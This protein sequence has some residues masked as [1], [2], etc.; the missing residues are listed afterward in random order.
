MHQLSKQLYIVLLSIHGLIRGR[1]LE[2]GRDADTGGQTLYVVELAHALARHPDVGKVD[3][4]TRRVVDARV[5]KDYAEPIERLSDNA[6]I[7]RI[8]AGPEDYIAKEQLW[9]H[10]DSFAD[11]LASFIRDSKTRPD[12][13][14][15]H[16]ADAG[17]VGSHLAN[18][19]EIPLIHTGHSLGRVKRSRLLAV[20]LT[21]QEMEERFRMS[22]RIEAEEST[23]ATAERVITSTHQEI[24]EQYEL[25]DHYQPEQ[26][27]V[28]PPGTDLKQ[29]TPPRGGELE[30][31]LFADLVRHLQDPGKPLILALSR[32]DRRK[33]ISALVEAYG[34]S[35]T[36][37]KLAN[38]LI[39]AGNRDDID[40]LEDGAQEVFHDL[41][42]TIDRHELYG[43]VALPKHHQRH[44]VPMIY[45]IAA[46]TGGVF[47]NPA[48][49][50]PFGLTLI[51]AAASGLPIVATEDGGPRD[52]IG[53]CQ[54]G[55]LIDPLEPDSIAGA[56]LQLLENPDHW[57]RCVKHGLQGVREHYSWEAHV[58]RYLE[59]I[60]PIARHAEK[61]V[62]KPAQ[63]RAELYRD[64]VIVSDLDQNLIGDDQSLSQLIDVLHR[65]RKSTQFVIATGRRIDSALK[66]MKKHGIP[67]PDVL[68]T[69]SGTEIYHAPKLTA[70]IAWAKHIDYHW[71]PHQV[72]TILS[73]YP[74]LENQP[75]LEQSRFKISYYFDPKL[76][77]IE[78]IKQ[79][80]H[81]EEQSV[82]V[83]TA[84]GQYLDILPLRASKG[85][86]LRYIADRKNIPLEAV[87]V[88]GGSGADE[89]MMRGNTLAAVVA[90]RHHE[91]LS[92][93]IDVERIYFSSEPNAAGILE[94]LAYYDFFASCKDPRENS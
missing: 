58:E 81:R 93:L 69:S 71:S 8:D 14:H 40:D 49:T 72:R 78:E 66:L 59:L 84:F 83:Q 10:L 37:Q 12:I 67:E 70:D 17:Y 48:L 62:R 65:H 22:R 52:I 3:L 50:E 18:L 26:M 27:C 20:G 28:I 13:L 79:M 87:F 1:E 77:D 54:N 73:G 85:M 2:L 80:L 63:R 32:P 53:N 61:L 68:I 36:L 60:R 75:K 51:E 82:H 4:I 94:A 41:L 15:S 34:Q 90:N 64:R 42:V 6:R 39:I 9:D 33:N 7:V 45:R 89:D 5:S 44:Q 21:S 47:V 11:N 92:Q 55:F 56:L 31:A 35:A 91:E 86:A 88:A 25:Y 76:A 23:L 74:G 19:L 38:L 30:S 29:F 43:K 16:Y 57:S 46:A 24:R